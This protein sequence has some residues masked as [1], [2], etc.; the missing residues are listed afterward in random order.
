[1]AIETVS[2][3]DLLLEIIKPPRTTITSKEKVPNV[4][5]TTWVLPIAAMN[6]NRP[7]AICFMLKSVKNCRKNLEHTD[8][9]ISAAHSDQC[10]CGA[11]N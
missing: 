7:R 1:M 9:K 11:F 8:N 6:R 2:Q 4:F 5:A 10:L 3:L